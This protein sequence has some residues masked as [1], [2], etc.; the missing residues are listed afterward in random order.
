MA[1]D[2]KKKE[3]HDGKLD[4]SEA[5]KRLNR[6]MGQLEGIAKML[7]AGRKLDDVLAQCKAAHSALKSVETRIVKTHLEQVL[8]EVARMEKRK[9]REQYIAELESLYKQAS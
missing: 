4:H 6:V 7:E 8:D 5:V 3:K 1:K 9:T 2:K